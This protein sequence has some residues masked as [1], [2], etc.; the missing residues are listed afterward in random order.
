MHRSIHDLWIIFNFDVVVMEKI[1]CPMTAF[2]STFDGG[3]TNER[4]KF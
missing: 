2:K 3:E 1:N 4:V